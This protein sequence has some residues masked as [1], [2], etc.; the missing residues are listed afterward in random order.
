MLL[1]Y[2]EAVRIWL[3]AFVAID[4]DLYCSKVSSSFFISFSQKLVSRVADTVF[5]WLFASVMGSMSV[6]GV[7]ISLKYS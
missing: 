4:L 5:V 3:N 6:S 1:S 7:V 2:G